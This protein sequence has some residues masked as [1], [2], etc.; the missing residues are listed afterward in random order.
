ME[1]HFPVR[2]VFYADTLFE[3]IRV[4][5]GRIPLLPWHVERLLGGMRAMGMEIPAEWSETWWAA[6]ILREAPANARV[7][8]T[9]WRRPG[10]LY[11]PE[12]NGTDYRMDTVSLPDGQWHWPELPVTVGICQTVRLPTDDFSAFKTLNA[13]R[14]VQAAREAR[15]R[16]WD[17][18]LLLNSFDRICEA[19][20]SNV[21]WWQKDQLLTPPLSEGCVSGTLRNWLMRHTTVQTAPLTPEILQNSDEIML[22]NAVRGII[23]A[24]LA[25]RSG[26]H[27]RTRALWEKAGQQLIAA[28]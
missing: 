15:S 18:G 21:F 7:R 26:T 8:I 1:D 17:D 9:V 14:Y 25:G 28:N 3:T 12:N 11:F 24:Q 6:R 13:A 2:A 10:G 27:P 19:T 20:G 22:T 4:F 23:P 16:G 5:D